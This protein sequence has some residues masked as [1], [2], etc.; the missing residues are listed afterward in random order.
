M[1]SFRPA[2]GLAE[3]AAFLAERYGPAASAPEPI[4]PGEMTRVFGFALDGAPMVVRFGGDESSFRRERFVGGAFAAP[5][6]PIPR[7]REVGRWGG[8]AFAVAER[9]P[10]AGMLGLPAAELPALVPS[11]VE[12]AAALARADVS[13]WRG[14]GTIGADDGQGR[15]AWRAHL[16]AI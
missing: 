10:G 2:L 4:A 7:V 11:M 3:A 5:D 12:T 8:T 13:A 16:A 6:R 15:A 1:G 9:L 14:F